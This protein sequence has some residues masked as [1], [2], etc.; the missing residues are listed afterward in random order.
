VY[1][2]DTTNKVV[3]VVRVGADMNDLMEKRE[4]AFYDYEPTLSN[5]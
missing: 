2:F 5:D 1:A 3:K 4:V